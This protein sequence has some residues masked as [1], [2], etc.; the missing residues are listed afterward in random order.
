MAKRI[1]VSVIRAAWTNPA[2]DLPTAAASIGVNRNTLRKW[3]QTL[4]LPPRPN[5]RIPVV[6]DHA[7]FRAMWFRG[8]T[9]R[10]IGQHFGLHWQTVSKTARRLGLTPRQASGGHPRAKV[11]AIPQEV[12][13]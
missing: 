11:A 1:P 7:E 10:D 9:L 4:G 13:Q 8:A 2:T 5:G 6:L 12:R 3:A